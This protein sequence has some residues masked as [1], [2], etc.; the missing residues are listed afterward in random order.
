MPYS[1]TKRKPYVKDIPVFFNIK[2][3]YL[4]MAWH[5]QMGREPQERARVYV[6]QY[7]A[8]HRWPSV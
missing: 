3:L 7:K 4:A 8:H 1:P 6:Q 5:G 2:P